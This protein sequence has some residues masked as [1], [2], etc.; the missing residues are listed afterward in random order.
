MS[1]ALAKMI[2]TAVVEVVDEHPKLFAAN[3]ADRA[4]KLI[5][6]RI[7]KTLV[8][9]KPESESDEKP[10]SLAPTARAAETV[11][12]DD[13]RAI[14]YCNLRKVAGAV[15]PIRIG[16]NVYLP[17]EAD[18]ECVKAFLDLPELPK[19]PLIHDK[20]KLQAWREFFDETLPGISRRDIMMKT[21]DGA[22]GAVLPWLWPPSKTGKTYEPEIEEAMPL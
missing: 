3:S 12:H 10:D 1:G 15:R 8:G 19:W 18:A 21:S 17:P 7:M 16:E 2:E 11:R 13:P 20:A 5:I 22:I 4:K 14:A 6:R 9:P